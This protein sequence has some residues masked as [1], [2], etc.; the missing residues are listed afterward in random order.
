MAGAGASVPGRAL[1]RELRLRRIFQDMGPGSAADAGA[2]S[3]GR[4]LVER[5]HEHVAAQGL[6]PEGAR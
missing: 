2:G 3:G 4:R 1:M 6:L 5:V